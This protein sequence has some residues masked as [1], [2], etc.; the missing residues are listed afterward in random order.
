[1]QVQCVGFCWMLAH[2]VAC[3][4]RCAS[5]V[6]VRELVKARPLICL[7]HR[8]LA[9]RETHRDVTRREA[10]TRLFH[11]IFGRTPEH[12]V[13][14]G[15]GTTL[16]LARHPQGTSHQPARACNGGCLAVL[17]PPHASM[18]EAFVE[19]TSMSRFETPLPWNPR[20]RL[21]SRDANRAREAS[22]QPT[23]ANS[24]EAAASSRLRSD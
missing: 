14:R 23:S 2:V 11:H 15:S 8:L 9:R 6:I 10:V 3:F 4:F 20:S 13:D 17:P 12:S 5:H 18:K 24:L 22:I 19:G 7:R 1:M 16:C 21:Q